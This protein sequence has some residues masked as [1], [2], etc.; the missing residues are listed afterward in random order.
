MKVLTTEQILIDIEGIQTPAIKTN[1][2]IYYPITFIEKHLLLRSKGAITGRI[3]EEDRLKFGIDFSLWNGGFQEET[4][5]INKDTLIEALKK[6]QPRRLT[7]EQKVRQNKLHRHLELEE[8]EEEDYDKLKYKLKWAN[9]YDEYTKGLIQTV[10][11]ADRDVMGR[12]CK[13]CKKIL[14]L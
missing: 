1:D 9:D 2:E 6:T 8:M 12:K 7:V 10:V 13:V 11:R 5:C 3:A 4:N 14:P